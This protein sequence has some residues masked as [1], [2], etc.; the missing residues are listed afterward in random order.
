MKPVGPLPPWVYWL[1]RGLALFLL[2]LVVVLLILGIRALLPDSGDAATSSATGTPAPTPTGKPVATDAET[3]K[4][5]ETSTATASKSGEVAMCTQAQIE[6]VATTDKDSYTAGDTAKL[7]M[8][9]TN[10]SKDPCQMDIGNG[11]LE[12]RVT[13]GSDR[14]WSSDDCQKEAK[15]DVRTIKPGEDGQMVSS[16]DWPVTRSA[17]GCKDVSSPVRPGNYR[18]IARAG[19]LQSKPAAFQVT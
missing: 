4:A 19:D 8:T 10:T 12:L 18:L 17:A 11:P 9:I 6:V 1:R 14:I 16:M 5:T 15:S 13:S 3:R 2:L 7:G